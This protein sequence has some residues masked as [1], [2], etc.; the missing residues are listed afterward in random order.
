MRIDLAISLVEFTLENFPR[1]IDAGWRV[2]T[3]KKARRRLGLC[4]Y[5][6][7]Q[8]ILSEAF[9]LNNDYPVVEE[10]GKHEIAHAL[11]PNHQHD[12]VWKAQARLLGIEPRRCYTDASMPLGKWLAVCPKCAKVYSMF[13]Q[14]KLNQTRWCRICG[15]V[16]GLLRFFINTFTPEANDAAAS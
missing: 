9:I 4:D 12:N 11:A 8:L 16:D 15:K 14:P 3:T 7:K 10:V 13:R 5:T 6:K 1:L 2:T